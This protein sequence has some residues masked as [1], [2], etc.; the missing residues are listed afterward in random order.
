[1]RGGL[2]VV[3]S[4][5]RLTERGPPAIRNV[6]G[7]MLGAT[8]RRLNEPIEFTNG[9]RGLAGSVP[10]QVGG[11]RAQV[12]GASGLAGSVPAQVGGARILG[13]TGRPPVG[14]SRRRVRAYTVACF[15]GADITRRRDI[16]RLAAGSGQAEF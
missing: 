3:S 1:M 15:P 14:S 6:L 8:F 12:G 2:A 13:G 11:S 4:R 7:R 9:A 10:A 5:L 16:A